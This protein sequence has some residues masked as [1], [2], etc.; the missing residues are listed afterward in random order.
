[1]STLF[2]TSPQNTLNRSAAISLG[3]Y[4]FYYLLTSHLRVI[5]WASGHRF[6][7]THVQRFSNRLSFL[8]T[9]VQELRQEIGLQRH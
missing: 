5:V 2:P 4:L 8:M 7:D 9:L 6:R 1:M 3:L